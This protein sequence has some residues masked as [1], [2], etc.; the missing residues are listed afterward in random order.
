VAGTIDSNG[1][2]VADNADGPASTASFSVIRGLALGPDGRVYIVDNQKIRML[3]ADGATVS[4]VVVGAFG[5]YSSN[6]VDGPCASAVFASFYPGKIA[7]DASGSIYMADGDLIRKITSP[8]TASCMVSTLAGSLNSGNADGTGSAASFSRPVV[9]KVDAAGNIYIVDNTGQSSEAIRKISPTGMV[10]TITNIL[11]GAH[12]TDI[13]FDS[14]GN[15]YVT[16]LSRNSIEKITPS[17]I[18]STWA[19]SLMPGIADGVGAQATFMDPCSLAMD[20]NDNLYV[21]TCSSQEDSNNYGVSD[22]RT[23]LV[24]K[25]TPDGQV[26]TIAGGVAW[27]GLSAC[28]Y[29][30]VSWNA[31][32]ANQV[33]FVNL[34]ALAV[35]ANGVIYVGDSGNHLI[36]KITPA[37]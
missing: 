22:F 19:G 12:V 8:G 18:I 10:T 5:G 17:G 20:V 35:N 21:G 3:S 26:T 30:S 6:P 2:G 7:V 14:K 31:M 24:R 13:A 37:Q 16:D 11:A 33:C 29:G 34:D 4:T 1:Y 15:L 23:D 32:P 27:A 9:Q 28:P 25:I 36:R